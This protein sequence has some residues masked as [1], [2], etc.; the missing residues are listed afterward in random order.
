MDRVTAA[1][2]MCQPSLHALH[3][4]A[5]AAAVRNSATQ[6]PNTYLKSNIQKEKPFVLQGMGFKYSEELYLIS[7]TPFSSFFVLN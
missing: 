5:T 1:S 2:S 6:Q 7:L 4:E 3:T